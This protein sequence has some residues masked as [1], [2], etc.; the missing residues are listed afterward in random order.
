MTAFRILP[1]IAVALI[2]LVVWRPW[3]DNDTPA[4]AA[5]KATLGIPDGFVAGF[6][7]SMIDKPDCGYSAIPTIDIPTGIDYPEI[8]HASYSIADAGNDWLIQLALNPPSNH[9]T[10]AGFLLYYR[11]SCL[12]LP[13]RNAQQ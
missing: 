6:S 8:P 9:E 12:P 10:P 13:G 11:T 1:A 5:P 7:R 2:A 3:S 4:T